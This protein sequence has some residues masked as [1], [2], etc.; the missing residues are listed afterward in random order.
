[1]KAGP[2]GEL[3]PVS[4]AGELPALRG[5]GG[6]VL[7]KPCRRAAWEA[8]G[9]SERQLPRALPAGRAACLA[10]PRCHGEQLCPDLGVISRNTSLPCSAPVAVFL[11]TSSLCLLH[12]PSLWDRR[13]GSK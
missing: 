12:N 13:V 7:K 4:A 6:Q 9:S 3:G 5:V 2:G 1:M 10:G 8:G 11:P